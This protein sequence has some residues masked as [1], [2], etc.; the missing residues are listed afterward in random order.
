MARKHNIGG[1]TWYNAGKSHVAEE[2]EEKGAKHGGRAHKRKFGGRTVGAPS[3]KLASPRLDKRARGGA[4]QKFARGGGSDHNPFSSAGSPTDRGR[5][6]IHGTTAHRV[7]KHALG[8][9]VQK[10]K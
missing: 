3:G 8:G 10:K 1:G 9:Q 7:G 2:A 5:S 4:I 6:E